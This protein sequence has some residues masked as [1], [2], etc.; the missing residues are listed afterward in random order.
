MIGKKIVGTIAYGP[1]NNDTIK[2]TNGKLKDYIEK[3]AV[4]VHLRHQK[5]GIA[6]L[7]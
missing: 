6:L 1:A 2:C 7:C 3:G 4:F 5:M